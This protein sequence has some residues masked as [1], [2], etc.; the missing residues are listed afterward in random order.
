MIRLH[1][2]TTALQ[3]ATRFTHAGGSWSAVE[4]VTAT[5]TALGFTGRGEGAPA[6]RRGESPASG[7]AYL[8]QLARRWSDTPPAVPIPTLD[9]VRPLLDEMSVSHGFQPAA[10]AA[11]DAALHDLR[12][13]IQG[14][15]VWRLLDVP[16]LGP[17]TTWTIWLGEPDDMAIR[18]G[19]ASAFRRLKVKLGAGDGRDGDRLSAVRDAAP[20]PLLVDANGGW[21]FE[22]AQQ[23][24][25]V[26][27]RMGVICVE[28]PLPV[29]DPAGERLAASAP[30]PLILD[31]ELTKIADLDRCAALG[32]GVNLKLS[33]CGGL[34]DSARIAAAAHSRGLVT[35]LGC[36]LESSLG[37]AAASHLAGLFDHVDLDAHLLLAN[38]P[39]QGPTLV[40]GAIDPGNRPGLGVVP[41]QG[42]AAATPT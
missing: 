38:D 23:L 18:A 34:V 16:R 29:D 6:A 28:Q 11:L 35:M 5:V 37:I 3:L 22:E 14:V 24:L 25:Q 4:V 2:E 30:L 8:D 10:R 27:A 36:G 41:R 19:A 12:G 7:V 39:W 9:D 33:K 20:Q 42:S 15:P 32:H 17:P 31:E 1:A 21:S 13:Q 26:A 40:D